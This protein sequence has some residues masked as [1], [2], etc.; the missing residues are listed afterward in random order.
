MLSIG[1]VILAHLAAGPMS[2]R[3][4]LHRGPLARSPVPAGLLGWAGLAR[5][6]WTGCLNTD[7]SILVYMCEYLHNLCD[8]KH[9]MCNC[10]VRRFSK[11]HQQSHSYCIICTHSTHGGSYRVVSARRSDS[12]SIASRMLCVGHSQ[13]NTG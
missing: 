8:V 12:H 1:L 6:A 13:S 11:R 4:R 3:E 9:M 2:R 10:M 5:L 7:S